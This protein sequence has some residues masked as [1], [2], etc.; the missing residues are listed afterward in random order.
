VCKVGVDVENEIDATEQVLAETVL[1]SDG[2]D[3][4]E[5]GA[6]LDKTM[7]FSSDTVVS[8]IKA[9]AVRAGGARVA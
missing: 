2:D 1:E 7:L 8:S 6:E 3:E 5:I 4:N 9:L